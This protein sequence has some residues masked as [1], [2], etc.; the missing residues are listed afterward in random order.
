MT[1]QQIARKQAEVMLHFANGGVIE[2]RSR[3]ENVWRKHD[4]PFWDWIVCDY[5]IAK[6]EP[7][8]VK[9]WQALVKDLNSQR[10]YTTTYYYTSDAEAKENCSRFIRLLPRT[11]IEVEVTE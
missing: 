7:K 10:L 4:S 6:P 5:R 1:Q 11:E 9:M 8:K 2:C 3:S